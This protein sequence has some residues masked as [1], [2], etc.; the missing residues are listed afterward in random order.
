METT[1]PASVDGRLNRIVRDERAWG[2][3][4]RYPHNRPCTDKLVVV[5]PNE[6]PRLQRHRHRDELWSF[7]DGGTLA[8]TGGSKVEVL[9]GHE[10]FVPRGVSHGVS[11]GDR[12]GRFLEMAL[13]DF[14]E[15]DIERLDDLYGRWFCQ[16]D[17]SLDL[18]GIAWLCSWPGK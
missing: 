15:S 3:F 8:E 11:G 16:S 13:G 9:A 10:I 18:E 5:V 12:G 1:N 4:R 6:P 7:I 2:R 17:R 14:D